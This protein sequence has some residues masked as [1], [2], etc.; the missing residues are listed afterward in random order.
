MDEQLVEK[1]AQAARQG[2]KEGAEEVLKNKKVGN[3]IS[4][5]WMKKILLAGIIIVIAIGISHFNPFQGLR[6]QFSKEENVEGHDLTLENN[7]FFGYTVADFAEVILGDSEQLKKLEVYSQDMSEIVEFTQA[8]LGKIKLFSKSKYYT[9]HGI[10]IY[11]VDLGELNENSIALD[12]EHQTVILKIPH[13]MVE[14]DVPMEKMEIGDTQKG[15]LAFG[16]LSAND[17]QMKQLT[18]EAKKHMEDKLV[19]DNIQEKADRMAKLSVWEI[20]QPLV[21]G[22]ARGYALEVQLAE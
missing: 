11:T 9:Y 15:V 18:T 4:V 20:Y 7:G 19:E 12:E 10:A 5:F 13:T 8:G 14:V 1:I 17:E 6:S 22:V 16:D 21:A 3:G 2:A